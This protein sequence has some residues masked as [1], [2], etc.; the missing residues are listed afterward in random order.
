MSFLGGVRMN[1]AQGWHEQRDASG[2]RKVQILICLQLALG[3][4]CGICFYQNTGA[5]DEQWEGEISPNDRTDIMDHMLLT[6]EY[7]KPEENEFFRQFYEKT[8][9]AAGKEDSSTAVAQEGLEPAM[10]SAADEGV[11][12][13]DAVRMRCAADP[14]ANAM[15]VLNE[16]CV[17][18]ILAEENGFYRIA[19]TITMQD[20][21]VDVTG[22]VQKES[23][24][25]YK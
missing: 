14:D 2:R 9:I 13:T 22:Y 25:L 6:G 19:I 10:P 15:A 20:R 24:R 5:A 12:N 18:R 17:V 8:G 21:D 4:V 3:F 7:A 23:V 11:I 1:N 16:G